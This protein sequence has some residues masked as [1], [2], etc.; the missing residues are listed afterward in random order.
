LNGYKS[1]RDGLIDRHRLNEERGETVTVHGV[2][3]ER[4]TED[5]LDGLCSSRKLR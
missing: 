2:A 5:D 1:I 4:V 3:D